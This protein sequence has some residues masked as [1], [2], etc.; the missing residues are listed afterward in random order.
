M[1]NLKSGPQKNKLTAKKERSRNDSDSFHERRIEI[2]TEIT[3]HFHCFIHSDGD[4]TLLCWKDPMNQLCYPITEQ[5]LNLWSTLCICPLHVFSSMLIFLPQLCDKDQYSPKTKPTLVNVMQN[6]P[7]GTKPQVQAAGPLIPTPPPAPMAA[8]LAGPH[9][10]FPY[11]NMQ[12]YPSPWYRMPGHPIYGTPFTS[13]HLGPMI[14]PMTQAPPMQPVE[15][16]TIMEWLAYCDGHPQHAGKD[17]S[18]L[19]Q[20]F[21]DEGF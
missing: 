3:K 10:F 20:K 21:N 13:L 4:K 8:G 16:P 14:P 17:F 19:M 1:M 7:Q 18:H 15:Y 11:P 5:H 2:C 6:G 12:P 9:P